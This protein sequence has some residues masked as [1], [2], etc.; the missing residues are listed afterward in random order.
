MRKEQFYAFSNIQL[1][2][3]KT[4]IRLDNDKLLNDFSDAI[5]K[6]RR[7]SRPDRELTFDDLSSIKT[8]ASLYEYNEETTAAIKG[9]GNDKPYSRT[10]AAAYSC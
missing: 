4:R 7:Y 2:E 8:M 10:N 9:L 3:Y 6:L 5:R 1:S